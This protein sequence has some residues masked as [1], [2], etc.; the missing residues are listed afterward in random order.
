[1]FLL[2]LFYKSYQYIWLR[3]IKAKYSLLVISIVPPS[4][5]KSQQLH[6]TEHMPATKLNAIFFH[7]M[8]EESE[9]WRG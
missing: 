4:T 1:M 3:S 7:F 9:A 8:E 2:F 5:G 6:S